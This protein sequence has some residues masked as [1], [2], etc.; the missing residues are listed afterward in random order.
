MK[1]L[2][3]PQKKMHYCWPLNWTSMYVAI[4][5]HKPS[6]HFANT[7]QQYATLLRNGC[8]IKLTKTESL[9]VDFVLLE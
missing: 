8:F 4:N 9:F 1:V 5:N 2:E 7:K 6:V 3:T